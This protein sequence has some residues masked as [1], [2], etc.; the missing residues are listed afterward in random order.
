MEENWQRALRGRNYCR[1]FAQPGSAAAELLDAGRLYDTEL[2][3]FAQRFV[4]W[5]PLAEHS[6]K[7][8]FLSLAHG[9]LR[10]RSWRDHNNG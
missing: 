8:A 7:I 5:A 1:A 10:L 2:G 6:R 3:K 4:P 9:S